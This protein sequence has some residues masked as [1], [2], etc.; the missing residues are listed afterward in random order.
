MAACSGLLYFSLMLFLNIGA[1][2]IASFEFVFPRIYVR[3]AYQSTDGRITSAPS[4]DT[5][6]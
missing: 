3:L 4:A 1:I 5:I 6:C 2:T